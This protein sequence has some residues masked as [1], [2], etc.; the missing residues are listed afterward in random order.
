MELRHS[1]QNTKDFNEL[2]GNASDRAAGGL[3]I[4]KSS[5]NILIAM[6]SSEVEHPDRL[7][8]FGGRFDD[9]ESPE[10]AL[11]REI[12]EET[13]YPIFGPYKPLSIS[14]D[15]ESDFA[16]HTHIAFAP[17]DFEP[18]LNWEHT[19]AE[20]VSLDELVSKEPNQLHHGIAQLLQNEAVINELKSITNHYLNNM[21]K[22]RSNDL[23]NEFSY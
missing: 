22:E 12:F 14:Y 17:D 10:E 1:S 3:I 4:S 2:V 7:G 5:G 6:R 16:Y 13:G 21:S 20:W 18:D 19:K 23:D 11:E 9:Y 15:R 8:I